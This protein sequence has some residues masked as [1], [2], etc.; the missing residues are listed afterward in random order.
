MLEQT[1]PGL[2][3]RIEAGDLSSME[4]RKL[5]KD[6]V[7]PLLEQGADSLVLGC[8]HYPFIKPILL[9]LVGGQAEIVD[10]SPAVARQAERML[11]EL[12]R[13]APPDQS[14]EVLYWSTQDGERL[15]QMALKLTDIGGQPRT[16]RW[17]QDPLRLGFPSP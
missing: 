9:E 5:L 12:N 14:G 13:A 17:F 6:A 1:L 15:A 10:P 2:V 16:I 11:Q 7:E 3:E 4:T 8:T